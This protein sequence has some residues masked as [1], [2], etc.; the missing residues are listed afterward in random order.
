MLTSSCD[1]VTA[2]VIALT[3][4]ASVIGVESG[5]IIIGGSNSMVLFIALYSQLL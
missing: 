1:F 4:I 3:F 2:R 5:F